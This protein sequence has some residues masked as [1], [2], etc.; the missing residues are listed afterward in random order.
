MSVA[1]VAV[2]EGVDLRPRMATRVRRESTS[3]LA[4]G[5]ERLIRASLGP[6][7][8]TPASLAG[9]RG[10][11]VADRVRTCP[12]ASV[13]GLRSWRLWDKDGVS[14]WTRSERVEAGR[15]GCSGRGGRMAL[16]REVVLRAHP[17][18]VPELIGGDDD[19]ANCSRRSSRRGRR[20]R[21]ISGAVETGRNLATGGSAQGRRC[22]GR[23]RRSLPTH[24]L[25]RRGV[26]AARR[27]VG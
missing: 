19:R 26:V 7:R 2:L 10:R 6:G 3:R 1:L 5:K 11:R 13:G 18:A 15:R 20:S 21:R 23:S 8:L 14:G 25:I 4:V 22:G 24:E 16:V 27:R 17:D 9:G 12:N